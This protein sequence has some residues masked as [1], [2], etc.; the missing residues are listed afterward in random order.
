MPFSLLN[1]FHLKASYNR[2]MNQQ[3]YAAAAKLSDAE[4]KQDR[5]AFFHSIHQTLN[6]IIVGDII[7]LGRFRKFRENYQHLDCLQEFPVPKSLDAVLFDSFDELRSKREQLD[8]AILKWVDTDVQEADF[9]D[10]LVF[11]RMNGE[12]CRRNFGEILFHFF[13]HQTHH[14][15]QI[16]TLLSQCDIDVGVTDFLIDVPEET[17]AQV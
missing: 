17:A 13:N 2:R 6:H 5:K 11:K 4:R 9:G 15:G 12:A 1:H 3:V 8:E 16:S 10:T 14:R 7:W